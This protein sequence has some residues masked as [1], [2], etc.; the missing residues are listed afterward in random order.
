MKQ[1]R[2]TTSFEHV[3]SGWFRSEEQLPWEDGV[4]EIRSNVHKPMYARFLHG[5]WRTAYVGIDTAAV[6]DYPYCFQKEVV[7][8]GI[9]K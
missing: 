1:T 6:E 4:Y 3:L 9:V 8:R 5:E 2:S 7:W